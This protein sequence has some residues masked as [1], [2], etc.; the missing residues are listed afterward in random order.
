MLVNVIKSI[1]LY[2]LAEKTGISYRTL[3]G[4]LNQ[5]EKALIL[6]NLAIS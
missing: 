4:P 3:N 2:F 1:E 5:S 6:K